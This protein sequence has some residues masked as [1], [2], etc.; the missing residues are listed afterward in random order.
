MTSLGAF[1]L[2]APLA[3]GGMSTIWR[4]SHSASGAAVAVKVMS[5]EMKEVERRAL[6]REIRA[7]AALDH[8]HILR[9]LDAGEV[10]KGTPLPAGSPY[11]VMALAEHGALKQRLGQM[12]WGMLQRML[13]QLLG[14]LAHAHAR[15]VVHRDLK[16]GNVLL[17]GD[18][19][20]QLADFGLAHAAGAARGEGV[21]M[22]T[23]TYMAPE[24]LTGT[25]REFGP[26]TDLYALGVMTW[27]LLST[28]PP[29]QGDTLVLKQAHLNRDPPDFRAIVNVPPDLESWLRR[30]LE[31]SPGERYRCAADALAALESLRAP[32]Q[33]RL[34]GSGA[35]QT[36]AEGFGAGGFVRSAPPYPAPFPATQTPPTRPLHTPLEG[37]GLG[38]FTQ[39]RVPLVGRRAEKQVLWDGLRRVHL[40]KRLHG[41]VLRGPAGV[42]KSHLAAW[43]YEEAQETGAAVTLKATHS[44]LGASDEGV[45]GALQRHFD[46]VGMDD[47]EPQVLRRLAAAGGA[48]LAPNLAR[49]MAGSPDA[50]RTLRVRAGLL[51]AWVRLQDRPVLLLLDDAQWSTEAL[52]LAQTLVEYHAELPLMVV[53]TVREEALDP[54]P[55]QRLAQLS[56]GR[57]WREMALDRLADEDTGALLQSLLRLEGPA[58]EALQARAAGNPLM[59]VQLLGQLVERGALHP[60]E[61]GFALRE[62]IPRLPDTLSGVWRARLPQLKTVD[63]EALEQAAAL[64]TQVNDAEWARVAD[65]RADLA[66]IRDALFARRLAEARPGGWSFVHGLLQEALLDR[67]RRAGRLQ[68]HHQACAAILEGPDNALR[69]GKHLLEAGELERGLRELEQAA[70][71]ARVGANP[72]RVEDIVRR[73]EQTLEALGDPPELASVKGNIWLLR[74]SL[75]WAY[76]RFEEAFALDN[77]ALELARDTGDTLMAGRALCRKGESSRQQGKQDAARRQFEQAL[78]LAAA[79]DHPAV[80]LDARAGLAAVARQQRDYPRAKAELERAA[81]IWRQAGARTFGAVSEQAAI[82]R[83]LAAIHKAQGDLPRAQ[84]A[85]DLALEASRDGRSSIMLANVLNDLGDLARIHGRM[86]DARRLYQEAVDLWEA[87]GSYGGVY[88]KLNLGLLGV[89]MEDIALTLQACEGAL[90]DCAL[91]R[92][93]HLEA[94]IQVC[95]A[96][97]AAAQGDWARMQQELDLAEAGFAQFEDLDP[98]NA[99]PAEKAGAVAAEAGQRDLAW[100]AWAL[101]EQQYLGL[102]DSVGVARCQAALEV[103]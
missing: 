30:L 8:P 52:P 92:L 46:A 4:A 27:E 34:M 21:V 16:P 40:D 43:L 2:D 82:L 53:V 37:V 95:L 90:D 89:A 9:V 65:R 26:W 10:P 41:V 29:F 13:R 96:W 84:R 97:A 51:A 88:P 75:Q 54:G 45:P 50:E 76:G 91:Y 83:S 80:E 93:H 81:A 49:W 57:L 47:P 35:S 14:A 3:Q 6:R 28:K 59:A 71:V 94:G 18:F 1:T 74:G 87:L 69:R 56:E 73:M 58:A 31:K 32:E 24:Q 77:L 17:D 25:W 63:Q 66:A 22:G 7:A 33:P 70:H 19:G 39:R 23:P 60:G 67:A 79:G 99:W 61:A 44:P 68:G 72:A 62:A 38:L 12:P 78:K 98:D 42:G 86:E 100:Q 5:P 36:W 101:A 48:H 20:V 64:G 85:L 102:D 55:R 103:L 11:L 15:G